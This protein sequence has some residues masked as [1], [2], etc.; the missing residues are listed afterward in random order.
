LSLV[1]VVVGCGTRWEIM[2]RSA[3]F[4]LKASEVDSC[5]LGAVEVTV[6]RG[7]DD[8][9]SSFAPTAIEVASSLLGAAELA[10]LAP[11]PISL[12]SSCSFSFV[13]RPVI[14]SQVLDF[15]TKSPVPSSSESAPPCVVTVNE[16]PQ[17]FDTFVYRIHAFIKAVQQ[18]PVIM[19]GIKTAHV[20]SLCGLGFD[21]SFNTH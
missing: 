14:L 16:L 8:R 10:Q 6:L 11:S 2:D 13:V 17:F 7:T 18:P 12:E 21:T 3:S 15:H 19:G 9:A 20:L 1:V 4:A 5:V